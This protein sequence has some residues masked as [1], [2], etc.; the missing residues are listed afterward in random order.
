M[1]HY[2]IVYILQNIRKA[3]I[4]EAIP[5]MLAFL[6]LH[7]YYASSPERILPKKLIA[8]NPAMPTRAKMIRLRRVMSPKMNWTKSNLKNPTSPQLIAPTTISKCAI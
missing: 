1:L 6:I 5:D 8:Y 3:S 4:T 7:P 2:N